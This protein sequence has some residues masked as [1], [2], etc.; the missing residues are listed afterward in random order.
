[1]EYLSKMLDHNRHLMSEPTDLYTDTTTG[2]HILT[3][4]LKEST[5]PHEQDDIEDLKQA[6]KDLMLRLLSD[7]PI[8]KKIT[9]EYPHYNSVLCLDSS[10]LARSSPF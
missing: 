4:Y 1:M 6:I 3:C 8:I 10:T 9:I 7:C 2:H 5:I